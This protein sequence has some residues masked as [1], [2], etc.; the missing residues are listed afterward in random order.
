LYLLNVL[1][2]VIP[3]WGSDN[4]AKTIDLAQDPHFVWQKYLR[5]YETFVAVRFFVKCKITTWWPRDI[6]I[7]VLDDGFKQ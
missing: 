6:Y 1:L 4:I 2:S 7:W 3:L 5:K